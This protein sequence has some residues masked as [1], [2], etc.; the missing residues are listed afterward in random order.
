MD[1][2]SATGERCRMLE[3]LQFVKLLSQVSM[4]GSRASTVGPLAMRIGSG[5]LSN[6]LG[7]SP[8]SSRSSR[9]VAVIGD[10]GVSIQ[11]EHR[12]ISLYRHISLMIWPRK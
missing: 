12:E 9:H 10:V 11:D 5:M 6:Q 1:H 7:Y 4:I 2:L 8:I 3:R